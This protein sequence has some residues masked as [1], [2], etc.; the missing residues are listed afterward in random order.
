MTFFF[1]KQ[2]NKLNYITFCY[3]SKYQSHTL[4]AINH[5]GKR[6]NRTCNI[7]HQKTKNAKVRTTVPWKLNMNGMS[8]TRNYKDEVLRKFIL[9]YRYMFLYGLIHL[10]IAN[11]T[12]LYLFHQVDYVILTSLWQVKQSFVGIKPNKKCI[13][14]MHLTV[15]VWSKRWESNVCFALV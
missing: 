7:T 2:R 13:G 8:K 1:L 15:R 4:P 5:S 10:C 6:L 12:K 3:I 11:R 9:H 14:K